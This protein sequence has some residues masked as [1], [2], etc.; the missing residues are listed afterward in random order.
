MASATA[1]KTTRGRKSSTSS[2]IGALPSYAPGPRGNPGLAPY[3][4]ATVGACEIALVTDRIRSKDEPRAALAQCT[5]GGKTA[6]ATG[7]PPCRGGPRWRV[8][9]GLGLRAALA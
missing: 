6:R 8:A 3:G 4:Q 5:M 7:S 1:M 2:F 9:N